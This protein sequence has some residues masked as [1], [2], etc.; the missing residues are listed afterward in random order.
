MARARMIPTR[1]EV[2]NVKFFIPVLSRALLRED[3]T[4]YV[5]EPIHDFPLNVLPADF[6]AHTIS[7]ARYSIAYASAEKR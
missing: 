3:C 4:S 2:K 1:P 5:V 6:Q 7:V